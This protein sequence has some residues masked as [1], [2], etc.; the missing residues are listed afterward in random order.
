MSDTEPIKESRVG[1]FGEMGDVVSSIK[2][3]EEMEKF[4]YLLNHVENPLP[5]KYER[6]LFALRTTPTQEH[7]DPEKVVT[8][9]VEKGKTELTKL[10]YTP[11]GP[12]HNL[13]EY[14]SGPID[15]K[16]RFGKTERFFSWGGSTACEPMGNGKFAFFESR[17]PIF[18]MGRN[19]QSYSQTVPELIVEGFATEVA[20]LRPRIRNLIQASTVYGTGTDKNID[21]YIAK[22]PPEYLFVTGINSLLERSKNIQLPEKNVV[23][24]LRDQYREKIASK[25]HRS[26]TLADL[27]A[28]R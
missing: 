21:A 25:E 6:L 14:A 1:P 8:N 2:L 4:G 20:L 13:S 10:E 7:F 11:R 5:E 24:R 18:Q 22:A 15:A 9:L 23:V 26:Y 12:I 28:V 3:H 27:F 16:D 17:V 19:L